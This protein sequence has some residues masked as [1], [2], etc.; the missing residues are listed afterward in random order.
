[1]CPSCVSVS[2]L[3]ADCVRVG[4]LDTREETPLSVPNEGGTM[5]GLLGDYAGGQLG[6]L[7]LE[8][9]LG[10]SCRNLNSKMFI[11][12]VHNSCLILY[13]L[14]GMASGEHAP[15]N[16]F[17]LAVVAV[18][19]VVRHARL[20]GKKACPQST[21]RSPQSAVRSPQSAIHSPQSAVRSPQSAVRSPQSAV[22]R[23]EPLEPL[24]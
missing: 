6:A 13:I 7:G 20:P 10:L 2:V 11:L 17:P 4:A 3:R 5:G 1:M 8:E 23:L 15:S 14:V 16:D 19:A 22:R 24:Q 18:G 9:A 21:V 12:D